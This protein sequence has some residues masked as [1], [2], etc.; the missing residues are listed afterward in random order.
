M[1]ILFTAPFYETRRISRQ[2]LACLKFQNAKGN[3]LQG[4]QCKGNYLTCER[5]PVLPLLAFKLTCLHEKCVHKNDFSFYIR[6]D[7]GYPSC[8]FLFVERMDFCQLSLSTTKVFI[9]LHELWNCGVGSFE[10]I[11]THHNSHGIGKISSSYTDV[12]CSSKTS[13]S[14]FGARITFDRF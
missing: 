9:I 11:N 14:I 10:G 2:Q 7:V 8:Y 13:G 6:L 12:G 3:S 1:Y 4:M 5:F